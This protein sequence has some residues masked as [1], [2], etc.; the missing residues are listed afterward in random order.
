MLARRFRLAFLDTRASERAISTI[1]DAMGK[2]L[3][4]DQS[5]KA[6]EIDQA[7]WFLKTMRPS[8][9]PAQTQ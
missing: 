6:A 1:A 9:S 8:A 3:Q 5:R 2:E 4:W 7:L